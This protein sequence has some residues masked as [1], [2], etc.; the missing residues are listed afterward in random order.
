MSIPDSKRRVRVHQSAEQMWLFYRKGD[1][2]GP[3]QGKPCSKRTQSS[4]KN[5]SQPMLDVTQTAGILRANRRS[6]S[7]PGRT[8]Q[9][10][11]PG[12]QE[13][14]STGCQERTSASHRN[15]DEEGVTRGEERRSM[16]RASSVVLPAEWA[17]VASPRLQRWAFD[18]DSKNIEAAPGQPP[19]D[20]SREESEND[21]PP[22]VPPKSPARKPVPNL[23]VSP[24]KPRPAKGPP[25]QK[26]LPQIE[27]SETAPAMAVEPLNSQGESKH[28][29]DGSGDS[30]MDRGRPMKR[31]PSQSRKG[32]MGSGQGSSVDLTNEILPKGWSTNS[33]FTNFSREEI[34]KLEHQARCQVGRF[35][36]FKLKDVKALSQ[37]P[38][39][40]WS[41]MVVA[42]LT[43]AMNSKFAYLM[44]NASISAGLPKHSVEIVERCTPRQSLTSSLLFY[45]IS[46]VRACSRKSR[47][48][49][50]WTTPLMTGRRNLTVQRTSGC[51][52]GK[53]YLS[54]LLRC[55]RC[56]P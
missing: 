43:N 6:Y 25:R 36:V 14:A 44:S 34:R 53:A 5:T 7:A 49:Q 12:P 24:L 56:P 35:E 32:F 48:W 47:R 1:D 26:A 10:E 8:Y 20:V 51:A 21:I 19:A 46:P 30:V 52:R 16:K 39:H 17:N 23:H 3:P 55:W 41:L 42:K 40:I 9:T 22:A 27:A 50:I 13:D 2:R 29:R 11:T 37:V 38:P 28:V 33:V 45:R 54:I 31:S 4:P 15:P 18:A